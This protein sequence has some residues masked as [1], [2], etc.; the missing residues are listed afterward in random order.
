MFEIND[1]PNFQLSA[2]HILKLAHVLSFVLIPCTYNGLAS[3]HVLEMV[4]EY[5]LLHESYIRECQLLQ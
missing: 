1:Y 3:G 2:L 5:A 4:K